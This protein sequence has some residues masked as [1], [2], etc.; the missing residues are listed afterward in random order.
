MNTGDKILNVIQL[1]RSGPAVWT[2]EEAAAKLGQPTSTVYRYFNSLNN[3]GMLVSIASG[4]YIL[5]PAFIEIDRII[6][7][8]DPLLS[9]SKPIMA[10]LKKEIG[11]KVTLLLCRYYRDSVICVHQ[12]AANISKQENPLIVSYERGRAMPLYRGASSKTILAHLPP[13]HIKK[14]FQIDFASIQSAGLG[15]NFEE[16]KTKLAN[17]RNQFCLVS[18]SEVD[19]GIIG[20]AAPIFQNDKI[21]IASLSATYSAQ[22]E[23]DFDLDIIKNKISEAANNIS[24]NMI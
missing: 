5:G 2:V 19:E 16:F 3:A 10:K 4:Q 12:E 13:H 23:N 8:N 18:K 21:I 22:N 6:R 11:D 1:F 17:I 15:G 20:I 14:L 24:R 9:F 7:E